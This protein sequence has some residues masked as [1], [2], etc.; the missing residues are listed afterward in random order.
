MRWPR[1]L[2]SAKPSLPAP[3]SQPTL[4]TKSQ[5]AKDKPQQFL[6]G[7]QFASPKPIAAEKRERAKRVKQKNDPRLIAAAREL[8]DRWLEQVNSGQVSGE[9]KYDISRQLPGGAAGVT[10][11]LV[12]PTPLLGDLERSAALP[13]RAA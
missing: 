9:G 4:K 1:V 11:A 2:P 12:K 10:A 3:R 6:C 13:L 8:R 7:F 5:A